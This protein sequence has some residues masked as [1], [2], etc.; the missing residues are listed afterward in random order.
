MNTSEFILLS[1]QP[2]TLYYEWQLEVQFLN[3]IDLGYD[4]RNYHVL[5]GYKDKIS[6]ELKDLMQR[7]PRVCWGIYEDS[8][9]ETKS[10]ISSLRPHIIKKHFKENPWLESERLF[11]IC[12]LYTSRC[13]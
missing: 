8:R 6:S 4:L 7:Y 3:L 2:D 5:V 1:A 13:V 12:L 10:Y 11:Y 9:K